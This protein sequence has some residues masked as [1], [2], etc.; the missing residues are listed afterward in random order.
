MNIPPENTDRS[1]SAGRDFIELT[2]PRIAVLVLIG[3]PGG[4]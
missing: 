3:F 4:C 1:P 2:K